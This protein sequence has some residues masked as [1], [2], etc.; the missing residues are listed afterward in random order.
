MRLGLDVRGRLR[1]SSDLLGRPSGEGRAGVRGLLRLYIYPL[2]LPPRGVRGKEV[3]SGGGVGGE[4]G[5]G[6]IW[7]GGRG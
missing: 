5:S 1:A 3:G 7:C 2:G 6:S 4:V